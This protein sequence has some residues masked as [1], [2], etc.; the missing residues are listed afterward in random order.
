MS[1]EYLR[2]PLYS[3]D[4]KFGLWKMNKQNTQDFGYDLL[5]I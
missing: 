1:F 5:L 2:I 4:Q 3:T